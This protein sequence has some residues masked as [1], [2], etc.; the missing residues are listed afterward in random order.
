MRTPDVNVLLYAV[1]HDSPQHE[2]ARTWIE[3]SFGSTS[4]I[5]RASMPVS[6]ATRVRMADSKVLLWAKKVA[7]LLVVCFGQVQKIL[8]RDRSSRGCFGAGCG[9][10]QEPE[11]AIV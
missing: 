6:I 2:T 3:A 9:T 5:D 11:R 7:V 8:D 1:N 4:S 10:Q